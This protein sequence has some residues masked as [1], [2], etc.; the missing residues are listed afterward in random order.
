MQDRYVRRKTTKKKEKKTTTT[1][2][3]DTLGEK[4]PEWSGH[5]MEDMI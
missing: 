5:R 3:L 2:E 1:Q 4:V